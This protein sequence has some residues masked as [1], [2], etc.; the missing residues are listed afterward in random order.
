MNPI[1]GPNLS[2]IDF[3]SRQGYAVA[4]ITLDQAKSDGQA[5]IEMIKAAAETGASRPA[6][7]PTGS[8]GGSLDTY[9]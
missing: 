9:A 1:S 5:A 2:A 6:P 4:K 8:C 3:D 7:D